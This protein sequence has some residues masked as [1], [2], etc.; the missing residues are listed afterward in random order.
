MSTTTSAASE[1]LR[2]QLAV[3][4]PLFGVRV[5][6]PRLTLQMPTDIDLLQ[7]LAVIDEGIHD[8][9]RMPFLRAWTDTPSPQRDRD[10]LAHWWQLR[11]AWSPTQWNWCGAVYVDGEPIGVQNLM[12]E[13]FATTGEVKTGSWIGRRFQGHGIGKEMRA[14]VLHLAFEGLGAR[15]AFS[16][17]IE[18]NAASQR[19]S[20][21]MGYQPVS[22]STI[23]VRGAEEQKK[24][25]VLERREWLRRRR[26][27]INI[28]GLD[29][30]AA[31]F[32][33]T[34]Q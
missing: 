12:G 13:E 17:F 18:G 22:S 10:S 34:T 24:M 5:V 30:T 27:D 25:V 26:D 16:G 8:P 29:A 14:A 11:S 31:A 9:A 3:Y 7:L 4:Q 23:V 20:E 15:R 33:V 1:E 32:G 28:F 2:T 6:T 21:A 19:V